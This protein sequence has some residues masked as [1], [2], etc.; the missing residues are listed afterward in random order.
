MPGRGLVFHNRGVAV[1]PSAAALSSSATN[2]Q[3]LCLPPQWTVSEGFQGIGSPKVR[4][5]AAGLNDLQEDT[6]LEHTLIV[7][8]TFEDE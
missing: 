4:P 8:T 6:E 2:A 3:T 7:K 5:K 1:R